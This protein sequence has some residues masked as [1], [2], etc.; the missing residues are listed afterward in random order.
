[1]IGDRSVN[2]TGFAHIEGDTRHPAFWN[3]VVER[4]GGLE[5]VVPSV[6]RACV[7]ALPGLLVEHDVERFLIDSF[8]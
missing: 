1:M 2:H 4:G 5:R 3:L 7:R 6:Q 8:M